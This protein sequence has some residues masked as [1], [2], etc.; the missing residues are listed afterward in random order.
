MAGP[1]D[2]VSAVVARLIDVLEAGAFDR[3]FV[4]AALLEMLGDDP[5]IEKWD[6]VCAAADG[7]PPVRS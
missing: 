6:A 3:P 5:R 4:R 1:S 2:S 7:Q